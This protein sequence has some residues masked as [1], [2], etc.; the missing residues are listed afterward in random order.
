M[1]SRTIE[2]ARRLAELGQT[3]D[4]LRAYTLA[5]GDEENRPA[6]E[7]RLEGAVYLLQFG[8]SYRAAYTTL[9]QLHQEGCFQEDILSLLTAIF[10]APNES[11]MRNRYERN[12]KLLRKYP[13]FFRQDFPAFEDLPIR[14]FP[15]DDHD[16]YIPFDQREG[17]FGDFVNFREPVV[18]HNFFKDLD[19]PI[20][21]ENIFS[22]YELEYLRDNV[23]RSED[24]GRENHIYLHYG[25][26]R[27]FCSYLQ[28]LHLRTLLEDE[29]FVFLLE[30]EEKD[31]PIDFK[32][33]FG[34][35][36]SQYPLR[37]VRAREIN[38]L[39]W[40]T[41][42]STHNGGD[43]FNE[44][45]DGHPNLITQPSIMM[46]IIQEGVD[47]TRS[48]LDNARSL[49]EA[50]SHLSSWPPALVEE[51]YH[52]RD[53]TDKDI[54]VACFMM[55]DKALEHL[56]PASRIAPAIFFQPHFSNII[57]DLKCDPAGN[58]V[59]ESPVDEEIHRSSIFKG[60]KYIK[61]FTPMRR[62]TTSH[63]ATVKFMYR[64]ALENDEKLREAKKDQTEDKQEKE[65]E[66]R[67]V[68]NDAVMT[69]ILNRSFMINP[70]D[71]LFRDSVLV[72][73][74][75]AK[76]NHKATFTALAE[77]LDLPFT[78]SMN[79]CSLNGELN[80]ESM[81]GNDLGFSTAAVYRKYDEYVND[82]ERTFIEYFL[83]DAYQYYGYDFQCYNGQPMDEEKVAALLEHFDTIDHY[84]RE[85]HS[86]MLDDMKVTVNGE[87]AGN[88][89]V[90]EVRQKLMD[91]HIQGYH[92]NRLDASK[93]LLKGLRFVNRDGQPLRMM[94]PLKLDPK[95]LQQPLYH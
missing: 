94:T 7:E 20:L 64:L 61:T 8:G 33:R 81:E 86:K 55:Q 82:S 45:F 21:A 75:D 63:G 25:S 68:V 91:D 93:L 39:I 73:F 13:Y 66:K 89:T 1:A 47:N 43:F 12:C 2:I 35:D 53:R 38:K 46:E 9:V 56:D 71:R 42:L 74:E 72:R 34:I 83:R 36:Y 32:E 23:R 19:D 92:R 6:P 29:K 57:Y 78:E 40:H 54:F 22:Q 41:Q 17:R 65:K 5:I 10:Y 18:R 26:W 90:E 50:I 16:G 70:T 49:K 77:F 44:I 60:F 15:Y 62:F 27:V 79:Y 84:I 52:L 67:N 11:T 58:T 24:I 76:L 37:P 95:L 48:T 31:Y 3:E 51:L 80:P 88:W 69:R 87:E 85:T 30:E 28:C 59:L 14:F 4:A